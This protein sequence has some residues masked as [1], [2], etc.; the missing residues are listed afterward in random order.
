VRPIHQIRQAADDSR[1]V[2][3]WFTCVAP[4]PSSLAGT[5]HLVVEGRPYVVETAPSLTPNPG[6]SLS[7]ASTGPCENRRRTPPSARY[8]SASW[9]T[10]DLVDDQARV[11]AEADE[12]VLQPACV[13][14]CGEAVDPL[15][16]GGE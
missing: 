9:R 16:G 5:T 8:H 14:G 11:A 3:H 12:F 4:I 7:P 1:D 13:M 15:A 2:N 6:L 10:A